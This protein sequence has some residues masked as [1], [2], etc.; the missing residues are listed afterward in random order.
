MWFDG[1]HVNGTI[2]ATEILYGDGHAG[3][4]FAF[5][6][7]F[8]CTVWDAVSSR[9]RYLLLRQHW[10]DVKELVT[11]KRIWALYRRPGA[12]WTIDDITSLI[13]RLTDREE[14]IAILGER[15]QREQDRKKP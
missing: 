12:S 4:E 5:H 2:V 9:W 15:K 14:V 10:S 13:Y 8:P 3:Q 1:L 7:I 11:Q 6:F